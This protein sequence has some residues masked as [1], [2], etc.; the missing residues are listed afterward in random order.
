MPV[1]RKADKQER[2][3]EILGRLEET[4]PDADCALIWD[5]PFQLLVATILSAQCSDEQVNKVTPELFKRY[6]NPAALASA[7]QE[8][9]EERIR[10]LGLFRNKAKS[11][12]GMSAQL[13]EEFDGDVPKAM[14]SLTSLPG[15]ARKTANCVLGTAYH[16]PSGVVVDTHVQRLSIR[17][18]LV[19]RTEKYAEKVEKALMPL[20]PQDKWV[21]LSHAIILHGRQICSARKPLCGECPLDDV[22]PKRI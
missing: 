4:Y 19:K 18:G 1:E 16:I 21:F 8:E 17:L 22:C 20:F 13:C 7:T 15:V 10:T 6:P 2:A 9:V 5:G 14:D 12:R 3:L 11:L